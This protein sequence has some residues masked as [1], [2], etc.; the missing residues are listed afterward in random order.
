M[1]Y[2]CIPSCDKCQ[3]ARKLLTQKGI[4]H[5]E[6]DMRKDGIAPKVIESW[7]ESLGLDNVLNKNSATWRALDEDMKMRV[8]IEPIDVILSNPTMLHR[9]ILD[10]GDKISVGKAALEWLNSQRVQ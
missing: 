7:L 4:T 3:M 2:Y 9:P 10:F 5:T 6:I 8:E 1:N